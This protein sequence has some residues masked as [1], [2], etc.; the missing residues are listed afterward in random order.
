MLTYKLFLFEIVSEKFIVVF[1]QL[2]ITFGEIM[3][4]SLILNTGLKSSA[5]GLGINV[6]KILKSS[7]VSILSPSSSVKDQIMGRKFAW[8]RKA[9]HYW[10]SSTNFLFSKVYLHNLH[11]RW[12]NGIQ[13]IFLFFFYFKHWS[14]FDQKLLKLQNQTDAT[15]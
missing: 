14:D 3:C 6:E 5:L 9:K 4:Q 8:D 11:W 2:S 1:C 7:L 10:E 15:D 12:W 13:A